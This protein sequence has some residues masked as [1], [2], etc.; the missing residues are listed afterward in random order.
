M[1]TT[2]SDADIDLDTRLAA[3][4]THWASDRTF[5]AWL[6]TSLS[7]ISFGIAIGKGGDVLESHGMVVSEGLAVQHFGV[8]FIALGAL[9]LMGALFQDISISKR[10]KRAGYPR[11]ELIPLGP[12]M[13]VLILGIGAAGTYF[14]LT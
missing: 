2:E 8:A 11:S 5:I 14:I 3:D 13:G 4:R 12:I 9:A 6:R 10:L 1:T 7:L